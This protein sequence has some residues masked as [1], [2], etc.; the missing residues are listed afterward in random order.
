MHRISRCSKYDT[1]PCANNLN[2]WLFQNV[3]VILYDSAQ[4]ICK[5]DGKPS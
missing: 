2:P 5:I 4:R 1:G 3:F